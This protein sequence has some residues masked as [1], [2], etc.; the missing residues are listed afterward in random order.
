M[1]DSVERDINPAPDYPARLLQQAVDNL[2]LG[3][4]IFDAKRELAYR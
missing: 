4:I 3:L 1:T 2:S